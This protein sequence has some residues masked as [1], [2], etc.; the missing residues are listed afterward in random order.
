MISSKSGVYRGVSQNKILSYVQA[1]S[2]EIIAFFR[3]NPLENARNFN[4]WRHIAH[5]GYDP[6]NHSFS[7]GK[8]ALRESAVLQAVAWGAQKLAQKLGVNTMLPKG[9]NL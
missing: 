9:V 2:P 6:S 3:A 4:T 7:L 8:A 5:E 1:L